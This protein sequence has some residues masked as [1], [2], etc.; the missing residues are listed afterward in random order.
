[1]RFNPSHKPPSVVSSG[2][3]EFS[4][5]AARPLRLRLTLQVPPLRYNLVH[6]LAADFPNLRFSLNG[7]ILTL[8]EAIAAL[9]GDG[10]RLSGV[11]VGRA[12]VERPWEWAQLDSRMYG[13]LHDVAACRRQV[14][15]KYAAF[16]DAEELAAKQRIRRLLL[17]PALN[18]FAGEPNGK[19][20]RREVDTLALDDSLSA[21]SVLLRSAEAA[22]SAETL[23]APPGYVWDKHEK[24][25]KPP[26]QSMQTSH[27]A[28]Q[29]M[30][31]AN[32]SNPSS[33]T[34]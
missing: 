23:D 6:Q 24:V 12:V 25:Y 3:R 31:S 29:E 7:G 18:L 27:N 17:A 30:L 4:R 13:E 26:S 9:S 34:L 15:H 1:M 21:G 32:V 14:L 28:H 33:A 16:A 22:L 10:H 20:F 11:M 19:I 2:P 5:P 8:D